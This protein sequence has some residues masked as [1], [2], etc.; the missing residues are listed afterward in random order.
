MRSDAAAPATR[1]APAA[2]C[3]PAPR[4]VDA[5]RAMRSPVAGDRPNAAGPVDAHIPTSS[6]LGAP[7]ARSLQRLRLVAICLA[8]T[9]L[10]F[11]QSSG[12]EAADTKLDLVVSP[13]R[14]LRRSVS[15]W[16]PMA[17]AGQLQNQAYGYLF[18][19]GPYYLVGKLADLPPW[20]V[21]R[22][23]ESALLI[24]AFLGMVRLSRLLGVAGFWPRIGGGLAYALAPRML[25]ELGVI[26]SELLPVVAL[27][28]VLIPLVGSSPRGTARRAAARSGVALLFAGGIN[29]AATL[30]ILPVP[31]LWLLSQRPGSRRRALVGWW[32][33]AVGLACLW[34]LVPLLVLGRYSPPFLNWIESAAVTTAPTSLLAALRGADHWQ[35]YLGPA[36]WPGGWVLVAAPAAILATSGVAACG[37]IG[38]TRPGTRHRRFLLASLLVGVVLVTLGH[39]SSVGPAFA[40]PARSLLDGPLNAFRNV[41]KFDPLIRLPLA[42]GV[43]HFL[44][45]LGRWAPARLPVRIRGLRTVLHARSLVLVGVLCLGAVAI[46]P[47]LSGTLVPQT[48]VT[49]EPAWWSQTGAWL[50]SHEGAGRALVV[51]GAAQPAYL[52]GE[53]RDDALQ[54]VAD[55][56]WTVRD[57]APLT[58]P[59]YIRLLDAI[60][61]RLAGGQPDPELATVLARAGIRYLVV[62]NDLDTVRS[63]TTAL[64]FV[65]ATLAG[66]QGITQVAQ[67]GPRT[68]DTTD[69][70]RPVD[71]GLTRSAVAVEVYENSRWRNAVSL[72][73]ADAAVFSSGSSE[74]LAALAED[75]LDDRRPVVFGPRP[76]A[77]AP[78][79]GQTTV[80]T[81]GIP[82]R[83]A[84]FGA[85]IG[86]SGTM[87][88][89]QAFTRVRAAQDYLAAA[90]SPLSVYAYRGI[91]GLSASSSGSDAGA[92]VNQS[93]AN[94]AWAALDG[95][96]STAWRTGSLG[97]AVG[98]WWQVSL[99]R[100][101][102]AS[103]ATLAFAENQGTY[104]SR[105]RITTDAG[106][107]DENVSPGVA[108]QQVRLPVGPTR[109]LRITVLGM[110][111]DVFAS[112]FGLATVSVP[113]LS[114]TR[115]L[116][117]P[118]SPAA[119]VLHFAVAE[120]R[121]PACLTTGA[122]AVCSPDWAVRGEE[123]DALDRTVSLSGGGTYRASADV[124]REPSAALDS[125]LDR[126]N[127]L[128]ATASS[129]D[130][131]DPRE[132]AG[133]AVDGDPRTSWVAATNDRTPTLTVT[134]PSPHRVD[135][136]V[137][138]T[139]PAA[140]A[141]RPLRI[142]VR[143]GTRQ[144]VLDVP[145]SGRV[146]FDEPV[147][148]RTVAVTV[149][150]STLRASVDSV[151]GRSRLL[152]VGISELSL[153]GAAV[154]AARASATVDTGCGGGPVLL[155]DGVGMPMHVTATAADVLAGRRLTARPC[156]PSAVVLGAGSHDLRLAAAGPWLPGT[157]TLTRVGSAGLEQDVASAGS[158]GQL[159]VQHWGATRRQVSVRTTRPALLAV[160]E[161]ANA[162]WRATLHGRQLPSV[163]LDGWQQG[164]VVP[165]GVTGVVTME[166]MPQRE[167]DVA[168][169]LG[170]LAAIVLVLAAVGIGTRRARRDAKPRDEPPDVHAADDTDVEPPDVD[171]AVHHDDVRA[172]VRADRPRRMLIAALLCGVALSLIAGWVG[173][174]VAV[175]VIALSS[176]LGPR[177]PRAA[178]ATLAAVAASA[179]L[180]A[181]LLEAT[182]PAGS[183]HPAANSAA[184]QVLCLLALAAVCGSTFLAGTP[185]R[186]PP[187]QQRS[188]EDAP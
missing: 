56:P 74:Q 80:L 96:P 182:H 34:W 73:P 2:R 147:T 170:L 110:V 177:R 13:F 102:D 46:A 53:P 70:N 136:L 64:R 117:V 89:E 23:W 113:G 76:A 165:A 16:D 133:A 26:S 116:V 57:Q 81:D 14:F 11:S 36:E 66:S 135:G 42:I 68:A 129:T 161:N 153:V 127:P 166:F 93:P 181:A 130:S 120:G 32:V 51:P 28:W 58:Q 175:P 169:P 115:T 55:G 158:P 121:R 9:L 98:Q 3:V 12:L 21:Q 97:G 126:G 7:A 78:A 111:N 138:G 114:A 63:Q 88:A 156:G 29:A 112:S 145:A 60:E 122:T 19:M 6:A 37:L 25:M 149:L 134:L 174:I 33:V 150:A 142:Q 148:A 49:N 124:Y 95:D 168:L 35:A 152:P 30:A 178:A 17:A 143:A 92:F 137:L 104:P 61:L 167:V 44:A 118:S 101:I 151:T 108:P 155:H 24:A 40:A 154:P 75:G 65:H 160:R 144:E 71:A 10:T 100:P 128:R 72:L 163:L 45:A 180:G 131:T 47:A 41:H 5:D 43:G 50:G 4:T 77:V 109:R 8:L 157:M 91:A 54:P 90:A 87:T 172:D 27:P 164:W 106:Q 31:A 83:E 139:D 15:M 48:R 173:V 105:V 159:T 99:D 103:I 39:P 162:G 140:P 62:R 1:A 186:R 59:G 179:L 123:D 52:W 119:D 184:A 22:S 79:P 185:S 146:S 18:P 85:V 188:L 82:R 86:Y 84:D 183:A 107:M 141:T 94:S 176:V 38:L 20:V 67:F 125:L 187:A 69:Q 132:R 171:A